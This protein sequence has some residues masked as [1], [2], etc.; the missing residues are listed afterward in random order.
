MGL[1]RP[2]C[3]HDLT[4]LVCEMKDKRELICPGCGSIGSV[5]FQN[6]TGATSKSASEVADD[7]LGKLDAIVRRKSDLA[8]SALQ[9]PHQEKR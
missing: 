9:L 6:S 8:I 7:I 1:D 5:I 4:K 2:K 3:G